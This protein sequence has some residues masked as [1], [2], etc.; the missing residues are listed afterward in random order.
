M[1]SHGGRELKKL[2]VSLGLSDTA[3]GSGGQWRLARDSAGWRRGPSCC[4]TRRR[5]FGVAQSE[6]RPTWVR[7][8]PSSGGRGRAAA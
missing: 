3:R 1:Q 4:G 8:P 5:L 2:C 6:F 7:G